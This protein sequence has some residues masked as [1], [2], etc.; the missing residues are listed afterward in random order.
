MAKTTSE[1]VKENMEKQKVVD[2]IA[3]AIKARE[4][5]EAKAKEDSEESSEFPKNIL[6]IKKQL[7]EIKYPGSV[8]IQNETTDRIEA[9]ETVIDE[10]VQESYISPVTSGAVGFILGA[11]LMAVYFK[12]KIKRV[13]KDCET[14]ISEARTTLDR[15]LEMATK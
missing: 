7:D 5:S 4:E 10:P 12:L 6:E 1:I 3:E 11:V 15:V 8:V 13:Q 2:Q 14:R 9:V